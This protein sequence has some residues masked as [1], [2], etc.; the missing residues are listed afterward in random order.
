M[1]KRI[2]H[3]YGDTVRRLFVLA[4]LVMVITLP[5]FTDKIPEPLPVALIAI[6]ITGAA[7][8]LTSPRESWTAVTNVLIAVGGVLVF[9]WHAVQWYSRYQLAN[10]YF[11]TNQLLAVIF[12]LALYFSFKTARRIGVNNI[13]EKEKPKPE[14]SISFWDR[15]PRDDGGD[16]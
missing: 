15:P 7:A 10:N 13:A 9:E 14:D 11:W 1:L 5:F 3:Y 12:L 8:G 2:L 6:L 4:A 16:S